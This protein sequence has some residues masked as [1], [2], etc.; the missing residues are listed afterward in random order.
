L[1]ASAALLRRPNGSIEVTTAA[2]AMP[3]PSTPKKRRR[4]GPDWLFS[5]RTG[6]VATA[7]TW[8]RKAPKSYQPPFPVSIDEAISSAT[9]TPRGQ[10]LSSCAKRLRH[11]LA[12]DFG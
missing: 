3:T 1:A 5:F 10:V 9:I 8:F 6:T 2:P 12:V 11:P 7:P 4:E